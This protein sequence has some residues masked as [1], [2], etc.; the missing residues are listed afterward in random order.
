MSG[1]EPSSRPAVRVGDGGADAVAVDH[2]RDDPAV[3]HVRRAG[4]EILRGPE[5]ADCAVSRDMALDLQPARIQRA[6]SPA[7][8]VRDHVLDGLGHE[9]LRQPCRAPAGT[10][11][12][13]VPPTGLEPVAFGLGNRRSIHLSYGGPGRRRNLAQLPLRRELA[14]HQYE[15][16]VSTGPPAPSSRL[17]P[18]RNASSTTKRNAPT[19]ASCFWTRCAA[20]QAVPPVASRSSTTATFSP[21]FTASTCDSRTPCPSSRAY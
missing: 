5:M 11:E 4:H 17:R 16:S 8:V 12:S 3:Q 13:L 1:S 21:G 6:A 20:P 18:L 19:C 2:R 9:H 10:G 15:I 7:A 14:A